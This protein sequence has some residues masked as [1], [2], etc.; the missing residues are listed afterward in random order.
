[1]K[2]KTVFLTT[3]FPASQ[4]FLHDFFESLQRQ[5]YNKFDV[6]VI[7]DAISDFNKNEYKNLNII[8]YKA[9]YSAAGNREYGIKKAVK[10]GYENIIFGDSDDYFAENRIELILKLLENNDVIINDLNVFNK[11]EIK[12]NFFNSLINKKLNINFFV[13]KNIAGLSNI[14]IKTSLLNNNKI[15]FNDKL[16]AVDWYFITT[17]LL[18][19]PN[20]KIYFTNKTST[21]YR[22]YEQ[23]T[24]GLN[25]IVNPEKIKLGIK[26]K[27]VHYKNLINFCKENQIS[28]FAEIYKEKYNEIQPLE[29]KIK[30]K[31]FFHKYLKV[32]DANFDTIF[33]GWWSEIITINEFEQYEN[34][35]NKK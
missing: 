11:Y 26:V 29:D 3:I 31:A 19:N 14:A 17:V 20:A 25:N 2:K 9:N 33:K 12:H 27:L 4:Q 1:M 23:N 30:N 16:V 24:I 6:I 7:N 32:I 10:L 21:F 35:T 22:Q 28:K 8:E 15:E 5:T 34:K 18:Q 13:N